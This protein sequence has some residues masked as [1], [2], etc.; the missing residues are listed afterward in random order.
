VWW[1]VGCGGT[2][3]SGRQIRSIIEDFGL[4]S[5]DV[6]DKGTVQ[7]RMVDFEGARR[8]VLSRLTVSYTTIDSVIYRVC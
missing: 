6:D 1:C 3:P 8:R 2:G 7:V 5:L 4:S